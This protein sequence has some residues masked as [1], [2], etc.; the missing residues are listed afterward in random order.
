MHKTL[1]CILCSITTLFCCGQK[2]FGV[3]QDCYVYKTSNSIVP[4]VY[5][6]TKNNWY[7][8]FRYNYEEDRTASFQFGKTFS[9]DG[10]AWYSITPLAGLLAGNFNGASI[11]SLAE[12]GIGKLSIY[13]EPEYCQSFRNSNESFFYNWAE[14]SFQPHKIFYTGLALQTTKTSEGF[15]NE[16]GVMLALTIKKFEIPLYFFKSSEYANYFVVG[17]HWAL[18]E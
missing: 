9:K 15:F 8:T 5:Y 3:D 13:T 6:Q 17:V 11:G 7:A 10:N 4:M 12:G 1:L 14:L 16:P 2:N 18:G